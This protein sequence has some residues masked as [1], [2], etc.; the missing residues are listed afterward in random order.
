MQ[1]GDP[2][3][4]DCMAEVRFRARAAPLEE[5][6]AGD[7]GSKFVEFGDCADE[8]ADSWKTGRLRAMSKSHAAAP[9]NLRH[10]RHA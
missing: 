3:D 9:R 4:N 7:V 8:E 5:G 6:E 1:P 10:V 2:G